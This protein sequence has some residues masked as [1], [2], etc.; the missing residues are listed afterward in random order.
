MHYLIH[1][2]PSYLICQFLLSNG[3]GVFFVWYE[4]WVIKKKTD[5]MK[6]DGW[7]DNARMHG[8]SYAGNNFSVLD[9]LVRGITF[10]I[11]STQ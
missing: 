5:G 7:V 1:N 9:K 8:A 6:A 11:Y 3:L 2:A 4:N 10:S